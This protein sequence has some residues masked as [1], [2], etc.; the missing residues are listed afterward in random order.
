MATS[1]CIVFF[2]SLFLFDNVTSEQWNSIIITVFYCYA[3]HVVIL[4]FL[5]KVVS[6]RVGGIPEVLPEDLIILCEPSVK[7]LCD[8]L[9][10]AIAQL[11]SG[12]LPSPESVHNKVKTFYT[13]RN[14]AER[15]EKVC[16]TTLILLKYMS[17]KWLFWSIVCASLFN[18]WM[19]F[20]HQTQVVCK[21]SG[22]TSLFQNRLFF[23]STCFFF[24]HDITLINILKNSLGL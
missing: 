14:V 21:S 18:F 19:F 9:E 10:K 23:L 17:G 11:R 15:T 4:L 16:T 5:S 6:T 13:W 3:V 1:H 24:P 22:N 7:S 12:K 20:F 8:G 2:F